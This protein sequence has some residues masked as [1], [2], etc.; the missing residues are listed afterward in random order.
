MA[1]VGDG[2]NDSPD[3]TTAGIGIAISAGLEIA[4]SAADFVLI[5]SDL[6]FLIS[7]IQLSGTFF[8][9]FKFTFL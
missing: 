5:K 8:R 3:L 9:R 6:N 4:I 7:L 2:V 1:I